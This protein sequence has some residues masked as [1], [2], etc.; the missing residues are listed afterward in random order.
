MNEKEAKLAF[1]RFLAQKPKCPTC[2]QTLP[3]P[4]KKGTS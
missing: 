4:K 1:D 2:G 3:P